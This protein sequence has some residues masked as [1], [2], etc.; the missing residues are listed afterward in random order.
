M[1]N[2]KPNFTIEE[3]RAAH[4]KAKTGADFPGYIRDIKKLGVHHYDYHVENGSNVYFDKDGNY[5]SA[6]PAETIQRT[7]SDNASPDMLKKYLLNHQQGAAIILHFAGKPLK[8]AWNAGRV[9]WK[10]WYVLTTISKT[11]NCMP[12]RF[13]RRNINL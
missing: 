9:T 5:V 13:P 3:I 7:V 2:R 1:T 6:R 12:N 10:R 11:M 8:R 4:A